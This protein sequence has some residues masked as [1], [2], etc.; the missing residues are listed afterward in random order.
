MTIHLVHC[1]SLPRVLNLRLNLAL[2]LSTEP[3]ACQ[4]EQLAIYTQPCSA[5]T[6]SSR[7]AQ[8]QPF[9]SDLVRH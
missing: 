8:S 9:S 7:P 2:L 4:T 6:Y 1:L 3:L 5:S